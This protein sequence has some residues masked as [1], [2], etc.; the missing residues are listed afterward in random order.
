MSQSQLTGLND[1][2]YNVDFTSP[3]LA[4]S[5]IKSFTKSTKADIPHPPMLGSVWGEIG[6]FSESPLAVTM[7][8]EH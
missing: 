5:F 3:W 7:G 1:I 2:L 6:D 4:L 8:E